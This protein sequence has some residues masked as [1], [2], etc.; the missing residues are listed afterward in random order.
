M[1]K[2]RL[3]ISLDADLVPILDKIAKDQ[4]RDRS[5][6]VEVAIHEYLARQKGKPDSRLEVEYQAAKLPLDTGRGVEC[7]KKGR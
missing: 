4:I 3:S 1:A 5:N 2:A 7:E 6:V